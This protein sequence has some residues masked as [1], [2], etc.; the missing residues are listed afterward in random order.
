MKRTKALAA[1][2]LFATALAVAAP[3]SAQQ[4]LLARTYVAVLG[5]Y[6]ASADLKV[7]LNRNALALPNT[8]IKIVVRKMSDG[9]LTTTQTMNIGTNSRA[10]SLASGVAANA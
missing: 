10:F 2:L 8:N 9:S 1:A 3:A 6:T 4:G 5:G 7:T